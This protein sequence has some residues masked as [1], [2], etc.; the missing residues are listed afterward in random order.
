MK[1]ENEEISY[2][3]NIIQ[4]FSK[5]N[6]E[7]LYKFFKLANIGEIV[8]SY[9]TSLERSVYEYV[10]SLLEKK[11]PQYC[12]RKEIVDVLS[13]YG[14]IYTAKISKNMGSG[15][16]HLTSSNILIYSF[17]NKL[18]ESVVH[19]IIHKLGYLGFNDEFY[20]MP[21]IL[22][23][24]GTELVANTI[25]EKPVCKE[26]LVGKLWGRSVGVES[27][28]LI[29][30]VLVNQLNIA[31]GNNTL[32][33]SIISGRNYIEPEI[34]KLIGRDKYLVLKAQMEDI[35]RLEK[36]CWGNHRNKKMEREVSSKVLSFQNDLLT[37]IFD[38]KMDKITTEKEAREMLQEL[39]EFSDYR[40]KSESLNYE[41]EFFVRYFNQKKRELEEKFNFSIEIEDLS[42]TWEARYPII[43]PD[44]ETLKRSEKEKIQIKEM[45]EKRQ[46]RRHKRFF[47]RLFSKKENV[48]L[49]KALE[50]LKTQ[51]FKVDT[52]EL[53]R[54][55]R[56]IK[57]NK[58]KKEDLEK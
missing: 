47:K 34:E 24:P 52:E 27:S 20:K 49:P 54:L 53:N 29:E 36:Q 55:E 40:V 12:D 41:D 14:N 19:E 39:M 13:S 58:T 44:K 10:A 43:K 37:E 9:P 11:Y 8:M 5:Y 26:L 15:V 32:E 6:E 21:L 50:Q 23:E 48:E 18:N 28:Y 31:C 3:K 51:D 22:L 4:S 33:R 7:E 56:E 45:A 17:L 30:T 46:G 35:S 57:T 25:L 2:Y 16:Y 1:S 42:K 38:L